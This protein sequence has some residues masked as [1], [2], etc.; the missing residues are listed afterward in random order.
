MEIKKIALD[1]HRTLVAWDYIVKQSSDVYGQ[2]DLFRKN[3]FLD[4]DWLKFFLSCVNQS[5]IELFI[6]SKQEAR[7]D[8]M[9]LDTIRNIQSLEKGRSDRLSASEISEYPR[10][11]DRW[12]AGRR[13][14]AV[15]LDLL[16]DGDSD[17]RKSIIP[18]NRIIL[19]DDLPLPRPFNKVGQMDYIHGHP[20]N[21]N[22]KQ[23]TVLIDDNESELFEVEAKGY[24]GGLVDREATLS[25]EFWLKS[26]ISP[27]YGQTVFPAIQR[28]LLRT[29]ITFDLS[30]GIVMPSMYMV[31]LASQ[32]SILTI[33]GKEQLV[34]L[35]AAAAADLGDYRASIRRPIQG[36]LDSYAILHVSQREQYADTQ[37]VLAQSLNAYIEAAANQSNDREHYA[38]FLEKE[39]ADLREFAERH[40]PKPAM[41][42]SAIKDMEKARVDFVNSARDAMEKVDFSEVSHD[43]LVLAKR[44]VFFHKA[45][46]MGQLI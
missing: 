3:S 2:P 17:L 32:L 28:Q 43:P 6:V 46:R 31:S 24:A 38:T 22:S 10:D 9:S 25:R 23:E 36:I 20:A 39:V 15:T 18:D 45:E 16:F 5:G 27:E 44:Q 26:A 34:K 35:S 12:I 8:G 33:A 1:F 42:R 7:F 41:L 37:Q 4:P 21:K 11:A 14:I 30:M 29:S 19:Y 40:S 13:L